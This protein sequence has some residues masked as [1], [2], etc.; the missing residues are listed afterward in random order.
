MLP[1]FYYERRR[2]KKQKTMLIIGLLL[3]AAIGF[4][5]AFLVFGYPTSTD[6]VKPANNPVLAPSATIE[7]TTLY[8]C[9]HTE[10][11]LLPLPKELQGKSQEE[12]GILYPEWTVLNFNQHFLVAEQ[13]EATEC[14]N[15]FLLFLKDDQIVVTA[16]KDK[17]KIIT[18]QKINP[19]VLTEEDKEILSKGIFISSEYELLEILES[20]Q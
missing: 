18:E 19:A 2:R 9:G 6:V 11:N 14:N 15:H 1:Q 4:L 8:S 12:T 5:L 3:L 7:L 13:K 20:F 16:S 17:A 10:T